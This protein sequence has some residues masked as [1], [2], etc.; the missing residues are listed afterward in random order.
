MIRGEHIADMGK[1][2]I[3]HVCYARAYTTRLRPRAIA[4]AVELME[5]TPSGHTLSLVS[6]RNRATG[7]KVMR[8]YMWTKIIYFTF[9]L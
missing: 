8:K 6:F 4:P 2:L 5:G 7:K 1:N 9:E 3:S